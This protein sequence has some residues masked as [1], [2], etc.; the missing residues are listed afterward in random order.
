MYIHFSILKM[1]PE[2]APRMVAAS[3]ADE[4]YI[5]VIQGAKGFR[6]Q[7]ALQSEEDPEEFL[8][9]SIWDSREDAMALFASPEY[10]VILSGARDMFE[11]T[12]GRRGYAVLGE[13][14]GLVRV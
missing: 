12:P 2:D 14:E 3:L 6:Y 8:S 4:N 10:G 13:L 11:G 7:Y 5:K 1:K 9:L